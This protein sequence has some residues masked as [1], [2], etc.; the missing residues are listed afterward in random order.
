MTTGKKKIDFE[1]AMGE[2]DF[3]LIIGPNG[4]LKGLFVPENDQVQQGF[5]PETILTILEDVYGMDLGDEAT[6][7]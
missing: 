2:E 3:G 7:H 6:I 1:S 4:E 5:V